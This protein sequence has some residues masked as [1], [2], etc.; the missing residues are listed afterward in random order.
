MA[1]VKSMKLV[2]FDNSSAKK[3]R[4]GLTC[5]LVDRSIGHSFH[6]KPYNQEF[7]EG[8][9]SF[10]HHKA[11]HSINSVSTKYKKAYDRFMNSHCPRSLSFRFAI[12]HTTNSFL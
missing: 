12:N 5:Y 3:P 6:F 8:V 2:T 7:L 11:C 10:L 1:M 9:S 4:H